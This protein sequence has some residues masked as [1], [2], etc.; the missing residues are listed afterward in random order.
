MCGIDELT[1]GYVLCFLPFFFVLFFF[2]FDFF[3]FF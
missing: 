2:F 3:S 1:A